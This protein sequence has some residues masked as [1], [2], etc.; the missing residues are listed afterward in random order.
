MSKT[1]SILLLVLAA[2][3]EAGGDAGVR[4][5]ITTSLWPRAV[6]FLLG[7]AL[8]FGYGYAVNR[9]P[10]KFGELLGLY[11][12]F[13][14]VVAQVQARLFFHET[15]SSAVLVGGALIVAGGLIIA[16]WR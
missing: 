6:W 7:A 12:V 13:F 14:F 16:V 8:L 15:P 5:G 3:L 1:V 11:V 9:P 4:K 2:V 10:W